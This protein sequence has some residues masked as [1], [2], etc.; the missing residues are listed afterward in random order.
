MRF[1]QPLSM[2]SAYLLACVAC[3]Y[4]T[5]AHDIRPLFATDIVILKSANLSYY[6]EMVEGFRATLPPKATVKEYDLGGSLSVGQEI[7]RGLRADPPSLVFAVGLK[8]TLSTKLELPDTPVVFSQVLNPELYDLP[9]HHMTGIRVVVS[10]D[11][12]LST[13]RTLLP[14]TKRIGLL[15][16]KS[17]HS[18]FLKEA[19]Q[20]AQHYGFT[21]IPAAVS[22]E[23]DVPGTLH[24]LLPMI[25]ALW[26]IQDRVVLTE[27]S[28]PFLLQ[29]LLDAKV[30]IFTFSDILIR[31]G[32]LGGL[33][34]QPSEL[35]KQAGM[36][37]IQLLRGNTKS[38]GSLLDPQQ[39]QLVLN[40]HIAE[41]LGITAPE[42][43]IRLAG[44]I[45]GTG[46]VAQQSA[47][48]QNIR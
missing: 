9:R 31:Q 24:Q 5:V 42:K 39:P 30:P 33:V 6:N 3:V 37:A 20:S 28:V 17:D 27:E 16:D 38:L 26:I 2:R 15:Y 47:P 4:L 34:L 46:T 44:T 40:L 12:Q 36:Q 45:Y 25:E 35:G 21:L 48:N 10:P 22:S 8:A 13:L 32:A 11:Q 29:T 19:Q 43:L 7:T 41:Y 23:S 14:H 1:H 18:A